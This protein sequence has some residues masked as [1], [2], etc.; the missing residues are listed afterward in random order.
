MSITLKKLKQTIAKL[1]RVVSVTLSIAMPSFVAQAQ[2]VANSHNDYLQC[3]P[4]Y[5]AYSQGVYSIEVDLF[6]KDGALLV[7]HSKEELNSDFTFENIYVQ[8]LVDIYARNG[9]KAYRDSDKALQLLIELK[10]ATE[11]TL[12][13]VV[14]V[15][16][17]YPHI[18]NP[19]VNPNA[20][21][22]SITGNVPKPGEFSKYPNF[23]NFDG[24]WDIDYT[25]Q[26]LKRISL[27]SANFREFSNWNGK[28]TIIPSELEQLERVIDKAHSLGKPIRFWGAPEGTTVYYTLYNMGIDYINTD[29]P[30]RY[31]EFFN[32]FAN[33]QFKMGLRQHVDRGV[34]MASRLDRTTRNF[35]GFDNQKQQLSSKRECYTPTFESDGGR[36]DIKNVILLIG[37]GMGL[38][39]IAAA[40]YVN[41]GLTMLSLRHLGLLFTNALN[42]FTTDSAGAGSALATG[43][44]T[45]NRHIAMSQTGEPHP[46]LSDHFRNKG[47]AVGVVTLGNVAD[48]TPASFYGHSTER[49]NADELIEYLFNGD[50]DLLCGS[51]IENFTNFKNGQNIVPKLSKQYNFVRSVDDINRKKGDVI[52]IDERMNKAAEESNLNLLADAT[53][54]SIAKLEE[55]DK[56]GFFLMVEGAK[57]DYGSH[58]RSLP[59]TI[60]EMISF[61]LAVAEALKFA[62]QNKNTLVVITADHD[63]G[64]LVLL[65]G[66]L[67]KG[68]VMGQFA[69]DDHTPS[70]VPLFS[71]G[72]FADKFTG[73]YRNTEV[74]KRVI[75]LTK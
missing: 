38:S 19:A 21:V 46:S 63:T 44:E 24:E 10:T 40:A 15:L 66:D 68:Y 73:V 36:E 31:A 1:L 17:R 35:E 47:A 62:D 16:E 13:A 37:D 52:C 14:S 48:A 60:I 69:T 12:S 26:E 56:N 61:D 6:Y 7:G 71:Y 18:F 4:F 32:N 30:E 75:S 49:D 50:L 74:A 64:G 72:P 51:G 41:G 42:A 57:I 33:K 20:V 9:N 53:R 3:V 22:I 43:V 34:S 28:G 11:P 65:D 29:H 45:A 23:I 2:I 5:Q 59:A 55:Q 67:Q 27:I 25:D 8:P 58:A 39:Q 70:P 54:A